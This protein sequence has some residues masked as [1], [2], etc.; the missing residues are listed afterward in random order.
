MNEEL[1]P[2]PFCGGEAVMQKRVG[3]T[4]RDGYKVYRIYCSKCGVIQCDMEYYSERDAISAWNRRA[5]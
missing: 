4:G 1:K 3:A 2:C 5:K